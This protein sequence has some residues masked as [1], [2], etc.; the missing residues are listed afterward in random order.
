MKHR[1]TIHG[2]NKI[3]KNTLLLPHMEIKFLKETNNHYVFRVNYKEELYE[4][5]MDRWNSHVRRLVY[6]PHIFTPIRPGYLI[7]K[8]YNLKTRFRL[9]QYTIKQNIYEPDGFVRA[10]DQ[11]M[12]WNIELPF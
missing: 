10:I 8:G 2:I 5:G 9:S 11:Y 12:D 6:D 4:I 7:F 3:E 1:L